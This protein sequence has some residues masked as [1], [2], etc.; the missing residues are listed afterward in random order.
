VIIPLYS[1]PGAAWNAIVQA[2]EAH[3]DVPIVAVIN[4]DNG[5]GPKLDP[6]YVT[7]IN[8]LRAA[9]VTVVGY[10]YTSYG[11]RSTSFVE[12]DVR[13][14]TSWYAVTG[15][16]FDEMANV[17]GLESYYS[18]LGTY[19]RSLGLTLTVGNPGGPIPSS[20]VGTLNCIVIYE[21]L[22]APT[23]ARL[24][25]ATMGMS[26]DN[27]AM[28]AYG[29]NALPS[30]F[31]SGA[32]TYVTYVY[33]TDEGMPN[34]YSSLP[35]YFSAFVAALGRPVNDLPVTVQAEYANGSSLNG[36]WTV[37]QNN[38]SLVAS[39]FTPLTFSAA[40]GAKY[41]VSV[42]NYESL[43]FSHWVGGS[44]NP[45]MTVSVT[46]ATTL[47][48]FY[49]IRNPET[50]ALSGGPQIGGWRSYFFGIPVNGIL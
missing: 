18:T 33:L 24:S 34:P 19:A 15:I 45:E 36:M 16:F 28:I 17:Q 9:G 4:P 50:G 44:T 13:T 32:S 5:P 21:N 49:V 38:G 46:Q 23:L 11:A 26:K 41:E 12:A 27:F 1:Y 25:E 35:S 47:T 48:A 39:G 3:P 42:A 2:K 7:W 30:S 31:E 14:Y 37:V 10:V 8:T 20:Y 22:G 6:N 43:T 40:S 29:V